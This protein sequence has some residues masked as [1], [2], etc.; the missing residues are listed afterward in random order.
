MDVEEGFFQIERFSF[1]WF[2]PEKKTFQ[3]RLRR[4]SWYQNK[5]ENKKKIYLIID[6]SHEL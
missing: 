3:V 1:V 6:V 2:S 5:M 4:V